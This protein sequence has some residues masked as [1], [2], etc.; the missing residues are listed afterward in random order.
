MAGTALTLWVLTAALA[1]LEVP[2]PTA[3][4]CTTAA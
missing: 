4:H 3:R 1:T 2:P